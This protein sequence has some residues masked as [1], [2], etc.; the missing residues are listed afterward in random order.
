[1][2]HRQTGHE[3]GT[4]FPTKIGRT[5]SYHLGWYRTANDVSGIQLHRRA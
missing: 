3:E 2:Y 4:R 5:P 1:M